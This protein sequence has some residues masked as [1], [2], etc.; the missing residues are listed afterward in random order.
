M[1]DATAPPTRRIIRLRIGV[2]QFQRRQF[3]L[4]QFRLRKFGVSQ[5]RRQF[6]LQ[7]FRLRKFG[8]SQQC[9][10][11]QLREPAL[12]FQPLWLYAF[13]IEFGPE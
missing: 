8:V 7:Q 12:H 1:G 3:T 13:R 5:Q 11:L 9:R 4:Q 2:G 6:T 10:Q